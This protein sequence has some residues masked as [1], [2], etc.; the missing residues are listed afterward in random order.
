MTQFSITFQGS[1]TLKDYA[2]LSQKVE[3]YGFDAIWV[4]DDLMFKPVWPILCVIAMNTKRIQLGPAVTHPYLRHPAITAGNIALLD[5]LSDRRAVLGIGRGAFLEFVG[6]EY[7]K[8]ITAVREAILF[9]NRL[10][11]GDRTPFKGELFNATQEAFLRWDPPRRKIPIFIGTW[12]RQMCQLA[13]EL[14]IEVKA[15][16]IWN[17][18]YLKIIKENIDIGAKRVG[19]NPFEC[20]IGV[21][22][23]TSISRNKDLAI[24]KAK[25]LIAVYLPFLSPVPQIAGVNESEIKAVREAGAKGDFDEGA[26]YISET[27]VQNFSL[28]GTPKDAIRQIE[29]VIEKVNPSHISFGPPFGPDE[30]E[31]FKLICEEILPYFR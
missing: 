12:G 6:M 27:S 10:L 7:H 5:E 3:E 22:S 25:R 24:A 14:A 29:N 1:K 26:K 13:G 31:A 19:R 20:G 16:G 28:S 2:R 23:T 17:I 11:S 9:I 30:D 4:Y 18:S 15:D 21:G 8:P